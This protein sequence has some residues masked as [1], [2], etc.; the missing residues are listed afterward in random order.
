MIMSNNS[1]RDY[2]NNGRRNSNNNQNQ[3]QQ[4]E[5]IPYGIEIEHADFTKLATESTQYVTSFEI[6][7]MLNKILRTAY[8]DFEGSKIV[9]DQNTNIPYLIAGFHHRINTNDGAKHTVA[10]APYGNTGGNNFIDQYK[11]REHRRSRGNIYNITQDGKDFIDKLISD[12]LRDKKSWKVSDNTW[13]NAIAG[14]IGQGNYGYRE[15]LSSVN[16][17]GLN[18]V[19]ELIY[20]CKDNEGNVRYGYEVVPFRSIPGTNGYL[21]MVTRIDKVHFDAV[22]RTAG[23]PGFSDSL[24]LIK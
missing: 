17:I 1:N 4:E 24:G 15:V 19:F 6:C 16:F 23:Y 3:E 11:E 13:D 20:G 14:E 21:F 12:H 18:K 9:M 10:F 5:R 8:E 22:L 7:N 2:N